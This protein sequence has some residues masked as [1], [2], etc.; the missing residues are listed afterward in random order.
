MKETQPKLPRKI[1]LRGVLWALLTVASLLVYS[2]WANADLGPDS[3]AHSDQ[4]TGDL[5]PADDAA[6]EAGE[7]L[8]AGA[9]E[10]ATVEEDGAVAA[11]G[12]PASDGTAAADSGSVDSGSADDDEDDDGCSCTVGTRRGQAF[13]GLLL[14]LGLVL[15]PIVKRRRS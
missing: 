3:G 11:D 5:A 9:G 12:A 4:G 8:E 7:T 15:I 2:G 1:W 13:S 14:L 6:S 10:D